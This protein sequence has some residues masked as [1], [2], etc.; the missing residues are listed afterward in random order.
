MAVFCFWQITLFYNWGAL[1]ILESGKSNLGILFAGP[2]SF[3]WHMAA[4]QTP[5]ERRTFI[6]LIFIIGF[7]IA[8]LFHLRKTS[9]SF[10]EIVSWL[11]FGALAISLS[12]AAWIEDWTFF[13]AVSQFCVL[14][15]LI[16]IASTSKIRGLVFG[17]S[18]LFWL[19]EAVRLLRH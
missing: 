3:L 2:G 8:T 12:R 10:H 14:G 13:R 7:T 16:I 18:G 11:L 17:C 1:P 5:F 4:L 6:E 19:M 15:A 9:A